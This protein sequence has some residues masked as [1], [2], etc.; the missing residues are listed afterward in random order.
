[1]LI[2]KYTIMEPR[3]PQIIIYKLLICVEFL[4]KFLQ[5]FS[6]TVIF[7]CH[8]AAHSLF[9][10]V[11]MKYQ[12]W[13]ALFTQSMI[14]FDSEFTLCTQIIL[15]WLELGCFDLITCDNTY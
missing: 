11:M 12:P 4:L 2:F 9:S 1:M 7:A 6:I 13:T 5:F 14:L 15:F 8:H 3:F 10:A